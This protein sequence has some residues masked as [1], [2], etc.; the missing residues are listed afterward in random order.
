MN[1]QQALRDFI[2]VKEK[3]RD[4]LKRIKPFDDE[5]RWERL[6]AR[7]EEL[8]MVIAQLRMILGE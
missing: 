3:R 5:V 8:D 2:E 1:Y 4:S 6:D 7:I